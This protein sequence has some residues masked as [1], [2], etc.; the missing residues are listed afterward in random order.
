MFQAAKAI[1][2]GALTLIT[3]LSTTLTGDQNFSDLT[4][5]QWLIVIGA[6]VV[7][8]GGVYGISNAPA[9]KK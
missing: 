9:K 4:A 3:G 8:V 6:T 5:V 2:A 7:A 1:Y